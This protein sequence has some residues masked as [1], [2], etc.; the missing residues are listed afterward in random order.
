MVIAISA[1][2]IK[3]REKKQYNLMVS[4]INETGV[5]PRSL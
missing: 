4:I 5:Y 1:K 2:R 3:K